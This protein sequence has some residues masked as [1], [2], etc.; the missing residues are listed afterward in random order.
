MH[1]EFLQA[2]IFTIFMRLYFYTYLVWNI[3][4]KILT[5][6][7]I[8]IVIALTSFM[9]GASLPWHQSVDVHIKTAYVRMVDAPNTKIYWINVTSATENEEGSSQTAPYNLNGSVYRLNNVGANDF[10]VK[11]VVGEDVGKNYGSTRKALVTLVVDGNRI[12]NIE[13]Q[14]ETSDNN[15][16]ERITLMYS[17]GMMPPTSITIIVQESS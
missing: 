6:T 14:D 4:K 16:G 17:T 2:P 10:I 1:E 3:M 15:Q 7:L 12:E 11:I 9:V 13:I 5:L 8:L